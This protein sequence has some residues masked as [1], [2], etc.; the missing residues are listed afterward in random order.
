MFFSVI[1]V[2]YHLKGNIYSIVYMQILPLRK[3]FIVLYIYNIAFKEVFLA[4]VYIINLLYVSKT[5]Q[6]YEKT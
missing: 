6:G 2:Q 5:H 4:V 1:Y 3:Y